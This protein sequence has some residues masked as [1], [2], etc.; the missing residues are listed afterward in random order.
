MAE[1]Y[2][3]LR[4]QL[5]STELSPSPQCLE[6]FQSQTSL[7]QEIEDLGHVDYYKN[8]CFEDRTALSNTRLELC[9]SNSYDSKTHLL[10][11]CIGMLSLVPLVTSRILKS[12]IP[13][14]QHLNVQHE[15]YEAV[16]SHHGK[17]T[18]SLKAVGRQKC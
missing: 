12:A 7:V 16:L 17:Q 1:S 4:S 13:F 3:I 8:L 10:S 11:V 5:L 6:T 9:I 15:T 14:L 18:E 2:T